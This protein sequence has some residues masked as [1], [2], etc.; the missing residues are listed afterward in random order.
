MINREYTP[1]EK[2]AQWAA[3]KANDEEHGDMVA[4]WKSRKAGKGA[5]HLDYGKPS[6][7]KQWDHVHIWLDRKDVLKIAS[8]LLN[9]AMDKDDEDMVL[10]L[11]L[12]GKMEWKADDE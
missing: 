6:G 2:A 10:P 4:E 8:R 12:S 1:E 11:T 5:W 9:M 7:D 3:R